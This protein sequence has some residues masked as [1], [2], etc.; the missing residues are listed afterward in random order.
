MRRKSQ[1]YSNT[2][3]AFRFQ[4]LVLPDYRFQFNIK[5]LPE[6][7]MVIYFISKYLEFI[8]LLICKKSRGYFCLNKMKNRKGTLKP[9]LHFAS[10]FSCCATIDFNSILKYFPSWLSQQI[11]YQNLRNLS[12]HWC[13]KKS[14]GL[15][16]FKQ[17]EISYQLSATAMILKRICYADITNYPIK[18][19][20]AG[21][22]FMKVIK[23]FD[24]HDWLLRYPRLCSKVFQESNALRQQEISHQPKA[25]AMFFKRICYAD[26]TS[27]PINLKCTTK[28]FD[29]SK[30]SI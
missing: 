24:Q 2:R 18:L 6:G 3:I 7:V 11:L 5:I 14:R 8:Q 13:V 10:R 27:C 20:S 12:S 22:L 23:I 17:R 28:S 30:I 9:K 1:R 16:L 21:A 25:T 15:F 4:I 29:L 26:I 19:F